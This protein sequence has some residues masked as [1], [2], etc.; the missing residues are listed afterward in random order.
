M[1]ADNILVVIQHDARIRIFDINFSDISSHSQWCE[2]TPEAV[3][4]IT[5]YVAKHYS[6]SEIWKSEPMPSTEVKGHQRW[7]RVMMQKAESK[8]Q[9]YCRNCTVEYGW[10]VVPQWV[11]SISN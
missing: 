1:S 6:R 9:S 4:E 11:K 8:C 3:A 5:A 2:S 7:L 10:E